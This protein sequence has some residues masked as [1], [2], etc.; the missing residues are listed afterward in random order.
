[1][2]HS[3]KVGDKIAL[4]DIIPGD[5]IRFETKYMR[6]Q[7]DTVELIIPM[8]A[9]LRRRVFC[10]TRSHAINSFPDTVTDAFLVAPSPERE[11]LNE[12]EEFRLKY[13]KG[14][15]NFRNLKKGSVFAIECSNNSG[16]LIYTKIKGNLW[17]LVETFTDG[18]GAQLEYVDDVLA[19]ENLYDP[20]SGNCYGLMTEEN[21][22][23]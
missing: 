16:W 8:E 12:A 13:D 5:T 11:R 20:K 3:Y 7:E 17:S 15:K 21:T 18:N 1:M 19:F 10:D 14:L 22:T 4:D 6:N 2:T 9:G 23:L